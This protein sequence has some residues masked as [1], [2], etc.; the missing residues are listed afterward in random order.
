MPKKKS[1]TKKEH[2]V[3]LPDAVAKQ[4]DKADELL[5][6]INEP[7]KPEPTNPEPTAEPAKPVEPTNPEPAKPVEPGTVP[8]DDGTWEQK[9][10]VLQGKYDKE[11][12]D[13]RQGVDNLNTVVQQQNALIEQLQNQPAPQQP[14]GQAAPKPATASSIKNLDPDDF[15]SYGDEIVWLVNGFNKLIE[16][17][18]ALTERIESGTAAGGDD[19]IG[20]LERQ[21]QETA[22]DRY[23]R[24]LD[25][26][27]PNWRQVNESAEFKAW[28]V[29][30]DPVTG[31]RYNDVMRHAANNL[32]HQQVIAMFQRYAGEKNIDLGQG[33]ARATAAPT[34]ATY[35]TAAGSGDGGTPPAGQEAAPTREELAKASA[36][37]AKGKIT[38]EDFNKI[39]DRFQMA[40][41]QRKK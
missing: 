24:E 6:E 40:E 2:E 3:K 31:Y 13:L 14:Q 9:Y 19:R 17:N 12:G 27:I 20:R 4:G 39:S 21:V 18:Q 36:L 26:Q 11:V 35:D 38:I 37:Y 30:I 8:V 7:K 10:K 33:Q 5:E 16:Q 41:A 25:G 32:R 23:L 1:T 34:G 29:T 28:L 22:T 15:A